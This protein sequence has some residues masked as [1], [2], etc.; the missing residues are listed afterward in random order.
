MRGI[1]GSSLKL[2]RLAVIVIAGVFFLALTQLGDAP[3]AMLPEFGPPTVEVQTE[4]LGLSAVEVEQLITA[5][6]EQ[7]LLNGVAFLD[8]I[9]SESVAGL[10][11][12]ELIFEPGTDLFNARQVVQERL[13]QAH[14]LPNVS[15][16]PQMLQPLSSTNRVM[17]IKLSSKDISLID[18]SVLTRWTIRP[19]LMG[20]AGVA[21]VSVWGQRDLQLQVQ[22]DPERL[23]G[24]GVTLQQVIE[25]TGNA[26]W[27]SPLSF[28]EASTP[29][30]GGFIDTPNQRLGI[31]HLQPIKNAEQLSAVTIDHTGNR[32]R[33]G[34][35]ADVVQNHQP[36]IGDAVF[37]DGPGLLLVVE[38]FPD[39]DTLK[40]TDDLDAALASLR[41]GRTGIRV[42]SSIFRPAG[43]LR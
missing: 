33:L 22:V 10:S 41:P 27:S 15:K 30:T 25:S 43:S 29:G 5:P 40:V 42:D 6:M 31:Q 26:L 28:L 21:N 12:I 17:M 34:D 19:R 20:V 37:A 16:P 32:L 36:L 8:A 24:R 1:I 38:K 23:R 14:A 4:A 39:A 11:S 7:D 2:R 13:S 3:V 9:R 35:V 18:M